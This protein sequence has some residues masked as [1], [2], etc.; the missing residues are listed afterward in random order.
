MLPP[1]HNRRLPIKTGGHDDT[2]HLFLLAF[3][4]FKEFATVNLLPPSIRLVTRRLLTVLAATTTLGSMFALSTAWALDNQIQSIPLTVVTTPSSNPTQN[5]GGVEQKLVQ[6]PDSGKLPINPQVNVSPKSL[7]A[8]LAPQSLQVDSVLGYGQAMDTS[9]YY[10]GKT[11]APVCGGYWNGKLQ[12]ACPPS[13][14]IFVAEAVGACPAGSFFDPNG[15]CWSCPDG[16]VR[17]GDPVTSST[18]CSRTDASVPLKQMKATFQGGT[19]P[20]GAFFDPIRGG[21]C[22]SCPA[23]Y[24]R[25]G[26]HIDAPNA[27]Y[28]AAGE[29]LKPAQRVK[30]TLWPHECGNGSFHDIWD[31]GGCWRCPSGYNRTGHHINSGQ[32]CSRGVPEKHATASNRGKS[33]CKANEFFDPRNSGECWTCPAGTY[34]TVHPVDGHQACEQRSGVR[35][36]KAVHVSAFSCPAGTFLDLINSRDSNVRARIEKQMAETGTRV[37]YGN[38]AGGTCWECPPG[39]DRDLYHVASDAAC[40]TRAMKWQPAPYD[41]PGMFGLP[42]STEVVQALLTDRKLIE[43]LIA[44][45][46]QDMHKPL[47]QMRQEVYGEIASSPQRS[48]VLAVAL[49]KRIEAAVLTP[50]QATPDELRLATSLA[51]ATRQ[52]RIFIAQNALDAYDQW[53]ESRG[54]RLAADASNAGAS[55]LEQQRLNQVAFKGSEV[56]PEFTEIVGGMVALNVAAPAAASALLLTTETTPQLRH[57]IYPHRKVAKTI[58]REVTNKVAK[59]FTAVVKVGVPALVDLAVE[60]IVAVSE[61]FEAVLNARPKLVTNLGSAKE[62]VNLLREYNAN[63]R[64]LYQQWAISLGAGDRA[65]RDLS[66]FATLAKT[67][68]AQGT[69]EAAVQPRPAAAAANTWRQMPGSANEIGMGGG[70]LWIVGTNPVP[71]G[72]GIYRWNGNAWTQVPGGAVRIDVDS[73]GY[74]WIVSDKDEIF[75]FNGNGWSRLPGLGKEIGVGANGAVWLL[76]SKA[77]A[78]GYEIYRWNGN[79]WNLVQGGAV[80]LDVDPQGNAWSISDNGEIYRYTGSGWV[81]MPGQARDIGIGADGSV[82]IAAADGQVLKWNGNAWNPHHGTLDALTVSDQGVPFGVTTSK[83]IWMGYP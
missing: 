60:M 13:P 58:G 42:G 6:I 36:E 35:L 39:Y 52:Y 53:V 7:N 10:A 72:F 30:R 70:T 79:G 64:W 69:G 37:S 20:P 74:A 11:G 67:A 49:Y 82:F 71:G 50:A 46:A 22:Y 25:S 45:M 59:S 9:G 65:P 12:D 14:A 77:V 32:A 26:A 16:Y 8:V 75:R 21:E 15:S 80:R 48:A 54:R 61:H 76:G 63:N 78:G 34:R 17:T 68:L 57:A 2:I 38:S 29:D 19:C 18:A 55:S 66:A 28:I 23:G 73:K 81:R 31:G 3:S 4:N 51:E 41:Q 1:R 44:A 47:A 43:S 5:P 27:C 33:Q 83:Q 56:P 40:H 24:R 62:P